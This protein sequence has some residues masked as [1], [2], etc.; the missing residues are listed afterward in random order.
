MQ[1]SQ[2]P[3]IALY[4]AHNI[5]ECPWPQTDDGQYAQA[6]LTPMI[7]Q[8]VSQYIDNI[9]TSMSVLKIGDVVLPITINDAE[10]ANSYVCS[11]Y[12]FYISYA[13][14]SLDVI[15]R[16]W[17]TSL[18]D[19][20]LVGLGK[21][22]KQFHINKVITVNNWLYSTNLYPQIAPK[23]LDMG[24]AY[25]KE[26]YPDHAIIFRSIDQ[27]TSP[28]CYETFK[29]MPCSI[30]ATRQVFLIDPHATTLMNSRLFKSDLKLLKNSG[31]EIVN[32]GRLTEA[33]IPRLLYLYRDLYIHKYSDLNPK[34]NENFL[35]LVLKENLLNFR[36]LKKDGRLDGVVGYVVRNGKMYCP[37]FGYDGEVP[38]EPSLYRLLSTVLMQEAIDNRLFFH[39]SSGASVFKTIR[40]AE[41]HIE[42]TAVFYDHLKVRRHIPWILLKS[43]YNSIGTHYM[44]KY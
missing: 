17:L 27:M 33:D 18:M 3:A 22:F 38:K 11:P 44:K 42:Y 15:S 25:L 5:E 30:I 13:R 37:F 32:N 16:A 26:R 1:S 28:V 24:I 43:L 4:H 8:G 23:Q 6:S 40:K 41:R 31:Y 7:K 10:Y 29:Q 19:F 34:F 21:F 9:Q 39:Q 36:A 2:P 12:S 20:V 14:E 35:R